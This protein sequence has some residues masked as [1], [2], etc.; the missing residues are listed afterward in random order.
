MRYTV[1]RF[2]FF[3]VSPQWGC[4]PL[5]LGLRVDYGHGLLNYNVFDD[6]IL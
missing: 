2:G 6:I 3:T 1:Y 5:K 4:T